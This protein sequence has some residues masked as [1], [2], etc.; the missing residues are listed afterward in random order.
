MIKTYFMTFKYFFTDPTYYMVYYFILNT[1]NWQKILGCDSN[2]TRF[3]VF[4]FMFLLKPTGSFFLPVECFA[5][6]TYSCVRLLSVENKD[7]SWF[8]K[9]Y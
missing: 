4:R 9:I 2:R 1:P 7:I 5:T 8:H 6:A 3:I